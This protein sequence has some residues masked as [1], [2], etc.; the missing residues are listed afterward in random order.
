MY[1]GFKLHVIDYIFNILSLPRRR[2]NNQHRNRDRRK[3]EMFHP[4]KWV[5]V[6]INMEKVVPKI[7]LLIIEKYSDQSIRVSNQVQKWQRRD[8][9]CE[10]DSVP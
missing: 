1:Y 9:I 10:L 8:R 7:N 6:H 4:R 2:N 5:H 3:F